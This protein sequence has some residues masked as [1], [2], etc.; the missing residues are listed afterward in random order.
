MFYLRYLGAEL[1]RRKGRTI[2][3]ASCLAFGVAL[4]VAVTALSSGLDDAQA[5]VLDPLTG[6]GTEMSVARPLAVPDPS[7][8][9]DP[10]QGLSKREQKQL[11]RERGGGPVALDDLG[12]P[13]SK[14]DTYQYMT[15]DLSFPA[16]KAKDIAAVDG[17]AATSAGL[18]VN[19][20]HI[21]GKVP[22]ESAT[23]DAGGVPGAPVRRRG[24]R[25]SA[26][27]GQLR[28]AERLRRRRLRS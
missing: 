7:A 14:F 20:T 2:L 3:T 19:V 25:R 28:L 15:S 17:V 1:R 5:E 4:V 8:Q 16:A 11:E 24:P 9:G 10:S 12:K 23:P 21:S 6:V 26:R 27:L 18:T 13:G 22:K